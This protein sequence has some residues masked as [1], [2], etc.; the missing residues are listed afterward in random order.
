ME[1]VL[2][3]EPGRQAGEGPRQPRGGFSPIPGELCRMKEASLP[4]R[5]AESLDNLPGISSSH[6]SWGLG[7]SAWCVCGG[8]PGTRTAFRCP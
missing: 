3:G 4:Y 8:V 2:P 6:S 5:R 1:G 7:G